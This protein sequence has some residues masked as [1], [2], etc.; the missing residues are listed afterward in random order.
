MFDAFLGIEPDLLH[1][2]WIFRLARDLD[3][4]FFYLFSFLISA[5][6]SSLFLIAGLWAWLWRGDF[7]K[8]D[9]PLIVGLF[10]GL[11][12]YLNFRAWRRR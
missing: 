12:S 10:L 7:A 5:F 9:A 11:Q 3:M 2:V 1:S 6:L 8:A 4:K